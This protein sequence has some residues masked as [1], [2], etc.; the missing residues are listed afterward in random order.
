MMVELPFA[1]GGEKE[2][3]PVSSCPVEANTEY[4]PFAALM[5]GETMLERI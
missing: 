5:G 3:H 1:D 4:H 2:R